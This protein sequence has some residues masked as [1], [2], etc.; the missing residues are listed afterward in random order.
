MDIFIARQPIFDRHLKVY[1]YELL[2][3]R[4][5]QNCFCGLDDDQAT[6]ELIYNSFL[7]M[8]LNDLTDGKRAFINFSKELI[9]SEVPYLLPSE[10]IVVEVLERNKATQA[11]KDACKKLKAMG[12]KI[13]LDDFVVD[14]HNFPLIELADIIKVEYP[15]VSPDVQAHL[16]KKYSPKIKFLA[17]K[18]ETRE[19]Y[20]LAVKMGYDY[21]QGYFFS[22]PTM[23]GSREIESLNANIFRVMEE[24]NH[25]EPDFKA[26]AEIIQC[27]LGLSYKLLKLVNSVY[28]GAK[29]KINTIPHALV[30]L[31]TKELHQWFS[32]MLLK[33]IQD[34]ENAEMIKLSLIRGK[35]MELLAFQLH[36][37]LDKT[38]CFFTGMFSFIDVLLNQP[39]S[40]VLNGLPIADNVKQA[41]L[42]NDNAY[43]KLLD[44]VIASESPNW[45][46]T[47]N[48]YPISEIGIKKYMDLYI[49]A[50][51]WAK[52]LNY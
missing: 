5:N 6:T 45:N 41:L 43:R 18:I 10:S 39:M 28:Y 2:Y 46:Y 49:D 44:C 14:E 26:I 21:F 19:D 47:E 11:T 40:Q 42:G 8:G 35:L 37:G 16:I 33:D 31:G 15:A 27:D 1:G 25:P 29:Y 52:D 50:L 24:L 12:Y 3:R 32:L 9:G 51:K 22:K 48:Q 36:S 7:V 4:D 13:A 34:V 17:E 23:I 30:Y 38:E 20:N